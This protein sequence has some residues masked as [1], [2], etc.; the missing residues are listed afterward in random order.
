MTELDGNVKK[1][2]ANRRKAEVESVYY[3]IMNGK[4]EWFPYARK[5][6]EN[7]N[8]TSGLAGFLDLRGHKRAR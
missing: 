6:A 3:R 1:L 8:C 4:S 5:P 7:M 2:E